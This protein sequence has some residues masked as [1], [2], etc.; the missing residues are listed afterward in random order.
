[1]VAHELTE[2]VAASPLRPLLSQFDGFV[3]WLVLAWTIPMG[4]GLWWFYRA[5]SNSAAPP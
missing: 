4:V 1:L 3:G 5:R 2:P